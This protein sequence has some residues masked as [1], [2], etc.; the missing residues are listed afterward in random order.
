[1]DERIDLSAYAGERVLLRFELVNDDGTNGPGWA[2]DDLAVPEIGFSDSAERDAGGWQRQGFRILSQELPQRFALQLVT[3]GPTPQVQEITLDGQNR[4]TIDLAGLGT[5]YP[6]A[7]I[8]V[9][10]ETDGTT[11][12]AGYR[13]NVIEGG[14]A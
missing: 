3:M 9:V 1:V 13:Y 7:V 10:G 6:K 5:D 11:E 14:G 12:R 4:A 8:V 2:I